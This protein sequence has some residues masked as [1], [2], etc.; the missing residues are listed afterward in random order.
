[1]RRDQKGMLGE[2][3]FVDSKGDVLV[4]LADMAC[5]AIAYSYNRTDRLESDI[6]L[7]LLRRWVRNI[8]PFK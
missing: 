1:M 8:W 7:R 2:L 6:Y 5:G 3:K 4:Q